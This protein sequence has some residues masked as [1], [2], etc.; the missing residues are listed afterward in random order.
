M[1]NFDEKNIIYILRRRQWVKFDWVKLTINKSL[2]LGLQL[3]QRRRGLILNVKGFKI[4]NNSSLC[5]N[6]LF[7]D[8]Q[9]NELNIRFWRKKYHCREKNC[10]AKGRE[11]NSTVWAS[12]T[13]FLFVIYYIYSTFLF[14]QWISK[15]CFVRAG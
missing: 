1:L 2:N 13:I 7:N 8:K 10:M 15:F 12:S 11:F 3:S 4:T 9:D 5:Y 6:Q 14:V